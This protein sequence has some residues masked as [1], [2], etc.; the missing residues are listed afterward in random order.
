MRRRVHEIPLRKTRLILLVSMMVMIFLV[1]CKSGGTQATPVQPALDQ[2]AQVESTKAALAE[3]QPTQAAAQETQ[4]AD[5][6]TTQEGE[7]LLQERCSVCHGV[8]TVTGE[9]KTAQ[10]WQQTVERM[11]RKGAKLSDAEKAVIVDYLAGK[12]AP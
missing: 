3:E 7:Q 8:R 12:Y 4:P 9:K 10:Q 1:S 11:M 5:Q 2:P 6:I